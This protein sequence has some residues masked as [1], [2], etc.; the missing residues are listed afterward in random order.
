LEARAE[1]LFSLG[2][3]GRRATGVPWHADLSNQRAKVLAY[4]LSFA[5][6]FVQHGSVSIATALLDAHLRARSEEP[7]LKDDDTCIL[8]LKLQI[9][10]AIVEQLQASSK[11]SSPRLFH[12]QER[13]AQERLKTMQDAWDKRIRFMDAEP[14]Q[15]VDAKLVPPSTATTARLSTTRAQLPPRAGRPSADRNVVATPRPVRQFGAGVA[16]QSSTPLKTPAPQ[17]RAASKSS[18]T[19]LIFSVQVGDSVRVLDTGNATGSRRA[20]AMAGALGGAAGATPFGLSPPS[21]G[22]SF[23]PIVAMSRRTS[24]PA[25]VAAPAATPV[26]PLGRI[27]Q[28]NPVRSATPTDSPVGPFAATPVAT[29][30]APLF[31]AGIHRGGGGAV[32]ADGTP[33]STSKGGRR[34]SEASSVNQIDQWRRRAA[35]L[36]KEAELLLSSLPARLRDGTACG[37]S[38]RLPRLEPWNFTYL[39]CDQPHSVVEPARSSIWEMTLRSAASKA[40]AELRLSLFDE[41]APTTIRRLRAVLDATALTSLRCEQATSGQ[42]S[43]ALSGSGFAVEEPEAKQLAVEQQRLRQRASDLL[44]VRLP[45]PDRPGALAI[46]LDPAASALD[47]GTIIGRASGGVEQLVDCCQPSSAADELRIESWRVVS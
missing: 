24:T 19:G 42:I 29:P 16:T 7:G 18:P 11:L 4:G 1:A 44:S 37:D 6:Q 40:V 30:V 36:Q 22:S 8:E 12:R 27:M 3:K 35:P 10:R 31:E 17:P 5:K 41:A 13:E 28:R 45:T 26:I 9:Q 43:F 25:T 47:G 39:L 46:T 32:C 15:P 34:E 38:A 33:C 14:A 23:A 21:T 20:E 2:G